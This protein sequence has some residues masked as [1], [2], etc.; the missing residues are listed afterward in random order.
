MRWDSRQCSYDL[1]GDSQSI[2]MLS[3]GGISHAHSAALEALRTIMERM[4]AIKA[5]T[6]TTRGGGEGGGGE[7]TTS[8]PSWA[9][10]SSG[11]NLSSD[12]RGSR[13]LRDLAEQLTSAAEAVRAIEEGRGGP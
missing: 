11:L 12:E 8:N 2:S 13:R 6:T 4:M 1:D 3:A 5:E 10:T 9:A 7:K